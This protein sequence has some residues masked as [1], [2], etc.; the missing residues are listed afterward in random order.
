MYRSIR[1]LEGGEVYRY[2]SSIGHDHRIYREVVTVIIA[3][4]LHLREKGLIPEGVWDR[5]RSSLL[6]L[7][8]I[9]PGEVLKPGYEDIFEAVEAWL[10]KAIGDDAGWIWLGR[11]RND[12]V[13]A[14]LRLY[15]LRAGYKVL[16]ES[17]KLRV[18]L[19]EKAVEHRDVILPGFTHGQASQV[20]TG[21][22]L[23]TAYEEAVAEA[24]TLVEAALRAS[25]KSPLGAGAGAGSIAPL[26]E[27]RLAQ[28]LGFTHIYSSPY[29]ASGSRLFLESTLAALAV[30]GVE[31]TRIA[32]DLIALAELG[33][34]RLPR[35]HIATSSIM[36]H[37]ENPATLEIIRS[38]GSRLLGLAQAGLGVALKLRY[39]YNL[40]LQEANPVL[41][42]ALDDAT[43]VLE[44]LAS[45]VNGVQLDPEMGARLVGE[46]RPWSS[47]LAETIAIRTQIPLRRAYSTVAKAIVEGRLEDLAREHDLD[48]ARVPEARRAGCSKARMEAVLEE[49]LG[50]ARVALE[51]R[52]DTLRELEERLESLVS[53]LRG[54]S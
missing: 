52:L 21:A 41:Y 8:S 13:A 31:A 25:H 19:A 40:D 50:S 35:G 27:A 39:S 7:S 53:L 18:A 17:A 36:P 46:L 45:V 26:D 10:S 38:L 28:L 54:Q 15:T 9:Q 42:Q 6:Q 5:V 44:A 3:H 4:A 12:H 48:P 24:E 43:L 22:C 37:K 47:E 29:Y 32:E 33:V 14:A 34:A 1:N 30:V 23:F 51:E 49:R 16:A 2:T 20:L 11:S